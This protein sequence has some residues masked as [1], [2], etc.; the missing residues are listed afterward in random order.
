MIF[1]DIGVRGAFLIDLERREDQRGFFARTFCAREFVEH[2]LEP[3]VAQ[4][5]LSY[6][7]RKGTLRGLH[8]Q[9]PPAGEVKLV[10]CGRGA[11]YD[12]IVDLRPD[13]STYMRHVAVE[14]NADNRRA[15]YI[16]KDVAHGFQTLAD[17]TEVLYQMNEF[18][19]PGYERGL[20]Y[21]D[22]ALGIAWP[23][24]VEAISERD[25]A[26]PLL[27]ATTTTVTTG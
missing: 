25:L 9:V 21:D 3:A 26:W 14:L 12:V 17:E 15:L 16:P 18:Y 22:P 10:R 23:L 11:I 24:P 5:N 13:S 8:Y 6:N 19:A 20:R 1:V 4:C 2:G 27:D 7:A